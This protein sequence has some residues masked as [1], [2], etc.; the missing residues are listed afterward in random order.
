M[1]VNLF[2]GAMAPPSADHV[3][4][5]DV[6]LLVLSQFFPDPE[7]RGLMVEVGAARPDFLSVSA[8]F[9]ALGWQVL[10]IEP[11][12]AFAALHR[13]RGYEVI[14]CACGDAD[15]D[16]VSFFVVDYRGSYLG[17]TV[18]NESFSSLGLRGKYRDYL[19][20]LGG[21]RVP[22]R[23]IRVPMRRLDTLLDQ[24][25]GGAAEIGVLSVDVEGWEIEV[26]AGLDFGRWR[27]A[28]VIVENLFEEPQ[29]RAFLEARGMRFWRR[30]RP[31]DI[32]VRADLLRERA[33]AG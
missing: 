31:N 14:E 27:P 11:N 30:L 3:V 8:S 25:A 32:F 12:P 10:A 24:H 28:V 5:G 7:T 23:E 4:E 21:G 15:R 13:A 9:R 18:T 22:V 1:T 20:R 17:G 26:L 19:E 16:A 29:H 2:P 6:D 33:R